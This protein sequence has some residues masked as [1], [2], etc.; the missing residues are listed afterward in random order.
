MTS[1]L[2][3]ICRAVISK[4]DSG[5]PFIRHSSSD[6]SYECSRR[7]TRRVGMPSS[8]MAGTSMFAGATGIGIVGV[9]VARGIGKPTRFMIVPEKLRINWD[10]SWTRDQARSCVR[11]RGPWK[12]FD[13]CLHVQL[14]H[15][16]CKLGGT[17]Y[18]VES[19]ELSVVAE[20]AVASCSG[21]KASGT[22]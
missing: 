5:F 19:C 15:S 18:C 4:R 10:G 1:A 12:W 14:V 2:A 20:G 17:A 6:A 11:A 22:L 13:H 9:F 7:T 16:Q 8:A 3:C 21:K